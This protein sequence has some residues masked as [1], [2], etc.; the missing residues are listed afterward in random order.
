M[1]TKR[2]SI[3][4]YGWE[5]NCYLAVDAYYAEEILADLE[6]LG[7]GED[8]YAKAKRNLYRGEMDSGFTYSNKRIGKSV[9]VVGKTS[10][11][12]E[13]INSI[14]HEL[15]HLCDDIASAYGLSLSGED[16]AYLTGDVAMMLAE[17]ICTLA[18]ECECCKNKRKSLSKR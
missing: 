10:S 13:E 18:C 14:A 8:I 11:R 9:L 15:R 5:V 12:E 16:V 7:C 2:L 3:D 6:Y 17:D 4:K 1:I